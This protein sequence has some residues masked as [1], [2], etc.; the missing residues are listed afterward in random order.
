ME[1]KLFD[2]SVPVSMQNFLDFLKLAG[3]VYESISNRDVDDND[4]KIDYNA[5]AAH[6]LVNG[7]INIKS[8]HNPKLDVSDESNDKN[9]N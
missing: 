3:H 5:L 4:N 8:G 1:N 6:D 7:L 2:K 9:G